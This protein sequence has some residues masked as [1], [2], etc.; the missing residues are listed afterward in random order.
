[1][2]ENP[3]TEGTDQHGADNPPEQKR[4][5]PDPKN[6][7]ANRN[8]NENRS[9]NRNRESWQ[10]WSTITTAIATLM[11]AVATIF[12]VC[13]AVK[14]WRALQATDA[15]IGTQIEA[16]RDAYTLADGT[17]KRQ[18]RPYILP[19]EGSVILKGNTSYA[20]TFILKN[21]GQTPAYSTSNWASTRV[22]D[23]DISMSETLLKFRR[24][25]VEREVSSTD[26][27]R[28][29]PYIVQ[30]N[31]TLLPGEV[32]AIQS[33]RKAIWMWGRIRFDD[34]FPN[35]K[36]QTPESCHIEEFF[37]RADVPAKISDPWPLIIIRND[38]GTCA[39][40][41]SDRVQ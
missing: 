21:T 34:F 19:V 25:E 39:T 24:R 10:K 2:A 31:G 38:I 27:A 40:M 20:T 14:Q 28:N 15:K 13:V 1:M 5:F 22:D 18:S 4:A 32:D 30:R 7:Q 29:I 12:N 33:G 16:M 3:D 9:D 17:A 36:D 6:P 37:A 11:I 8:G 23:R 26:L 41:P 35:I